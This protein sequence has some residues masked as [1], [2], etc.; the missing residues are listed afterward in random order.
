MACS[1]EVGRRRCMC[2]D[3]TRQRSWRR[4]LLILLGGKCQVCCNCRQKEEKRWEDHVVNSMSIAL[5][6]MRTV[7]P[8]RFLPMQLSWFR[9]TS[10]VSL[11][12]EP[13]YF[14]RESVAARSNDTSR[15]DRICSCRTTE[16]H[17]HTL[18]RNPRNYCASAL[19]RHAEIG[20]ANRHSVKV[21]I[22]YSLSVG[23]DMAT[24]VKPQKKDRW[25]FSVRTRVCVCV[26]VCV[27][28]LT[29]S[30]CIISMYV[31]RL[32]R[33]VLHLPNKCTIY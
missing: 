6:R 1:W 2:Q 5:K 25:Y 7:F 10:L 14:L 8:T 9:V 22:S 24:I 20:R 12:E 23:F 30:V 13:A 21:T 26:C 29:Q 17:T 33:I 31:T 18:Y 16:W 15:P 4:N 3:S 11:V 28:T 19:Q 27:R 32:C